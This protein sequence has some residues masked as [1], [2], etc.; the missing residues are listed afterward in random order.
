MLL[1]NLELEKTIWAWLRIYLTSK[2]SFEDRTILQ[3]SMTAFVS[4]PLYQA[5]WILEHVN[6]K[7][8]VV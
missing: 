1:G 4:V 5:S 3:H 6:A 7:I 2:G 8:G